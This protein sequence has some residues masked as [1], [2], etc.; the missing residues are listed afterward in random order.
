MVAVGNQMREHE[1]S[2]TRVHATTGIMR[3]AADV[4]V[5]VLPEEVTQEVVGRV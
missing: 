5:P 3:V 2:R 1:S 4:R